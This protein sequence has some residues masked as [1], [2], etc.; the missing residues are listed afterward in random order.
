MTPEEIH[1]LAEAWIK[2]THAFKE[3]QNADEFAWAWDKT[4]D[5]RCNDPESLWKLILEISGLDQSIVVSEILAAGPLEDL[6][7]NYGQDYIAIVE[8]TAQEDPSFA[9]LLGGVWKNTMTNEVWERVQRV[10]NRS[11]WDGIPLRGIL[12][13]DQVNLLI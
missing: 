9:S 10:W 6:L 13:S 12:G 2:H 8:K 7:S 4:F 1:K 11:G 3:D 5:L